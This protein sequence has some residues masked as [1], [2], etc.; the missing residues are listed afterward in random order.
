MATF[1]LD[2]GA[3]VT[4]QQSAGMQAAPARVSSVGPSPMGVSSLPGPDQ[5]AAR[6]SE[7]LLKMGGEVL[8]PK[9]AEAKQAQFQA[10]LQRAMAG[11][12]VAD[13]VADQPWY[14]QI[15]GPSS[16]AQGARAYAVAQRVAQFGAD[17][18]RQM[19]KLAEQGPE[20]LNASI[21]KLMTDLRTGDPLAD[22][23]IQAQMVDQMAPLYKRHAKEHYLYQQ[24]QASEAQVNSWLSQGAAYQQRAKAAAQGDKSVSAADVQAD[25]ERLLGSMGAFAD[26]S[27][28][29]Y[30]RNVAGFLEMSA[31]QGNYHVIQAF[32]KN[33]LFDGLP[34]EQ[35]QRLEQ[36]FRSQ[37]ARAL[38]EVLPQLAV[39]TAM[40][41][42]D[43]TQN[44]ALIP[45][46]AAEL[47]AKAAA[48]SGVPV[49]YAQLIPA[50][51][52]DNIAGSVLTAQA[53]A[54]AAQAQDG[55]KMA[56]AQQALTSPAG[57][58]AYIQT[59]VADE[60]AV[61]AAALQMW[62]QLDAPGRAALLNRNPGVKLGAIAATLQAALNTDKDTPGLQQAAAVFQGLDATQKGAYFSEAQVKLL[63]RYV[64]YGGGEG[65]WAT[66]RVAVPLAQDLLSAGE[67][68][69][70][71]K[72]VRSWAEKKNETWYYRNTVDDQSLRTIEAV[73]GRSVK[74]RG[75]MDLDTSVQAAL[76]RAVDQGQLQILGKHAI[77]G[78]GRGQQPLQQ[79][80]AQNRGAGPVGPTAAADAFEAVLSERAAALGAK[81]DTYT[82]M[83][84]PDVR[85]EA[86]FLV[87]LW[88]NDREETIRLTSEEIRARAGKVADREVYLQNLTPEERWTGV[89]PTSTS[90]VVPNTD[91]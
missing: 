89:R 88:A 58:G 25:F 24:R 39:E 64:A 40:F 86:R 50:V 46:R 71:A 82:I 14:T 34:P 54:A 1:A 15:F 7:L 72:A 74:D 55:L 23:A 11:E 18:E 67:K 81:L 33:G 6:T 43:M 3:P 47:N 12:A 49:E 4:P 51:Q 83:R 29:S 77:I 32:R 76:G 38:Q 20:A 36:V 27:D 30:D 63:N 22:A 61:E 21:T 75:L 57:A 8:A 17:M 44:P 45:Q 80:F 19:P 42:K 16:A 70:V 52:L 28:E 84:Q 31:G 41:T 60:K 35:R 10:G 53:R 68:G 90:P 85:G 26:Q 48:L 73:I 65:A 66:A 37:G 78:D 79:L 59:G 69:E 87:T 91:R 56:V 2:P 13:I 5:G 9:I 62:G